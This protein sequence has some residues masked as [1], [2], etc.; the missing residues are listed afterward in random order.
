MSKTRNKFSLEVR[1]RA[2]RMVLENE[3]DDRSRWSAITSIS[4]KIGYA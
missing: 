4:N 3:I 1:A 2:V